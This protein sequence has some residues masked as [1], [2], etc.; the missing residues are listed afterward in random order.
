MNPSYFY[1]DPETGEAVSVPQDH[2]AVSASLSATPSN[3][4][5]FLFPTVEPNPY[6]G[7]GLPP[8]PGQH[9]LMSMEMGE[10]GLPSYSSHRLEALP[11][12]LP[13]PLEMPYPGM[14]PPPPQGYN[15]F[16]GSRQ[17]GFG[18]YG[19]NPF[20]M[21]GMGGMGGMGGYGGYGM[22]GM[23]GMGGMRGYGMGG[24]GMGGYGMGGYGMNPYGMNPYGIG[25]YDLRDRSNYGA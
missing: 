14:R 17:A 11:G 7:F 5:G 6:P 16:D 19:M 21:R 20:G 23:P 15:Y 22:G 10:I 25:G 4:P 9:G 3:D 13:Q 2:S 12:R 24:Y 8:Y 1:M 18:N